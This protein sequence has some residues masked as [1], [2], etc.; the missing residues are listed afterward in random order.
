MAGG[1]T[2]EKKLI[3]QPLKSKKI[4]YPTSNIN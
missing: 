2:E 1:G 3:T 4:D